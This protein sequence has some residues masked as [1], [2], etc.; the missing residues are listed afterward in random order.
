MRHLGSEGARAGLRRRYGRVFRRFFAGRVRRRFLGSRRG[1]GRCP[2]L[3]PLRRGRHLFFISNPRT[4]TQ[5]DRTPVEEETTNVNSRRKKPQ[6]SGETPP[7]KKNTHRICLFLTHRV[8]FGGAG[9]EVPPRCLH[10]CAPRVERVCRC[11]CLPR[12]RR[13]GL[14]QH[15]R[16][17]APRR[18]TADAAAAS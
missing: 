9:L 5:T 7:Q 11:G 1:F 12:V 16:V 6:G 10:F 2:V 8:V 15:H 3:G 4:K 17:G 18:P 14:E 13:R